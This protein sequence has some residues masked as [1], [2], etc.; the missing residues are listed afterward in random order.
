[1]AYRLFE[2]R[3]VVADDSNMQQIAFERTGTFE[4]TKDLIVAPATIRVAAGAAET[5]ITLGTLTTGYAWMVFSDYPIMIRLNGPSATQFTMTSNILQPVNVGAPTPAT[6]FFG[7]TVQIT[8][9]RVAPITSPSQ[10][11][12]VWLVATG[13]PTNAYT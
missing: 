11:A 9:L 3:A 6:C 12:N 2:I 1:M 4:Q 5:A 7:G 8:S 13:D 10:T